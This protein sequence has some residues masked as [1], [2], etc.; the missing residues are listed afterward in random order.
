VASPLGVYFLDVGQGDCSFVVPPAGAGAVLFDC[1]DAHVAERFVTDHGIHHLDA[2]IVSHLDVDHIR[3]MVSFLKAFM[4]GGGTVKALYLGLDG[5]S[6]ARSGASASALLD[7]AQSWE[8]EGKLALFAPSREATPK[9]VSTG[10]NWRVEVVL[11]RYGSTLAAAR[12]GKD[13][14]RCS[15][16]VRVVCADVAVLIGGDAPLSSWLRLEATLNNAVVLRAPHHG[17]D[18]VDEPGRDA[19]DLYDL[20]RPEL[21]VF[22]VGTNNDFDHPSEGHVDAAER[23]GR[24]RVLCTQLTPRCHEHPGERLEQ[25]LASTGEAGYAYRH[26]RKRGRDEIIEVPCAGAIVVTL[27][28]AGG[29][30]VSPTHHGWH[31]DFVATL[32]SPMCF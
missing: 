4:E 7:A 12:E 13:P 32:D 15:A 1:N 23:A 24:C 18:I 20:V 27:D 5:P 16:V 25:G 29:W 19:S 8:K 28:G 31:E 11:P 10:A 21:T 22:S 9:V 26:H 2:A 3:G 14:N 30:S 6:D 17:G